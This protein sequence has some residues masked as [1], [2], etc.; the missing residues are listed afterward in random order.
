MN[1]KYIPLALLGILSLIVPGQV[2][3]STSST[4]DITGNGNQAKL[5]LKAVER[6]GETDQVDSFELAAENTLRIEQGQD[7]RITTQATFDKAR[8]IDADDEEKEIN[9]DSSGNVDFSGYSQGSYKLEVITPDGSERRL[10]VGIIVIGPEDTTKTKTIVDKTIIEI[11]TDIDCGKGWIER[12]GECIKRP[13]GCKPWEIKG[14]DGKCYPQKPP[15]CKPGQTSSNEKP[16]T[17]PK[18]ISPKPTPP[19]PMTMTPTP[20][21]PP[22]TNTP[23][24]P[25]TTTM[26]PPPTPTEKGSQGAGTP[27]PPIIT[28]TSPLTG[29][30]DPNSF[31]CRFNQGD[32][33]C[34]TEPGQFKLPLS[35]PPVFKT[36]TPPIQLF[37]QPAP[38]VE[39]TPEAEMG[40][41]GFLGPETDTATDGLEAESMVP[42]EDTEQD[43]G[44]EVEEESEESESEESESESE[45][46]ESESEG[47]DSEGGDSEE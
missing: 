16:C 39:P 11:T 32:P 44:E 34:A 45:G 15:V 12:N 22:T 43:T 20:P 40:M 18:P 41:D 8:T 3:A 5:E 36:P 30:L 42:E 14:K 4:L 25:P 38:E 47:G 29:K 33:L 46:S 6:D 17:P 1:T 7:P 27:T 26:S 13:D 10:Y 9:V 28:L 2:L 24:P 37:G 35:P 19:T 23:T 21:T 31:F